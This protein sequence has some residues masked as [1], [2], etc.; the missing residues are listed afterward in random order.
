[1]TQEPTCA[2]IAF[3]NEIEITIKGVVGSGKSTIGQLIIKALY[4]E[5]LADIT[6]NDQEE[7]PSM[8]YFQARTKSLREK[9]TKFTI[10]MV[11]TK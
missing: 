7:M 10:N 5:G 2:I 3:M 4:E 11:Q 6:V 9:N 8:A 1:M